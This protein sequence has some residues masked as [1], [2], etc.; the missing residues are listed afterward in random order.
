MNYAKIKYN[1]GL[2]IEE[3]KKDLQYLKDIAA[4][5]KDT[6]HDIRYHYSD[7]V[8]LNSY[9]PEPILN[10]KIEYNQLINELKAVGFEFIE[11]MKYFRF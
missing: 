5:I 8:I 6:Y 3:Y 1:Q 10:D 7:I 4:H 2:T 9:I 11:N